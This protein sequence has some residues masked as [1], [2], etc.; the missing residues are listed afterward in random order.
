MPSSTTLA[1]AGA[2]AGTIGSIITAFGANSTLRAL[3]LGQ[4]AQNETIRKLLS[5]SS[6]SSISTGLDRQFDRAGASGARLVWL[7]VVLLA[8]GFISQALSVLSSSH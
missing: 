6:G 3:H 1:I 7:G 5:S 4:D 8:L 2:I